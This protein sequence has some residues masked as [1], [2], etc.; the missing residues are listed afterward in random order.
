MP[1]DRNLNIHRSKFLRIRTFTAIT[2]SEGLCFTA[3]KLF[4]KIWKFHYV[5][6]ETLLGREKKNYALRPRG[7]V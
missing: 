5:R 2:L 3:L 1:E 6:V 7:I 4:F